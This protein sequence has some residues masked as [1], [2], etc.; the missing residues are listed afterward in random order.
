MQGGTKDVVNT[1]H[2]ANLT[3]WWKDMAIKTKNDSLLVKLATGSLASNKL[4]YHLGCYLS[5]T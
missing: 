5:M 4:F 2:K 3:E 1:Q